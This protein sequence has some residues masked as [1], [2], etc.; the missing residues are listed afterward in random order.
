VTGPAGVEPATPLLEVA[1]LAVDFSTTAGTV[2]A[3]RDVDLT[4][5]AGE[6]LA[7]LGES[8]SGK[9]VTALAVMGL[10]PKSSATI[11]SGSVRYDGRDLGA[12][13]DE[14]RRR[15]RGSEIAMVFQDPLSSLNPV[16]T[17]GAQIDEVFRTHLG[18][19]KRD[20]RRRTVELM[21]RVRIDRAA[22]RAD[23]YPHQFS[24]GMRQRI[25]IA[26]AIALKPRVLIADEP[27]TALD[28]T[29]QARIIDLLRELRDEERMSLLF[30]THDLGVVATLADEVAV[31]Y[32]GRVVERGALR[33]VYDHPRHPYTAG[34][35]ASLPQL[36]SERL[37]PIPGNPPNML[38]VPAGCAF[39]P[40][41]A[42]AVDACR[43]VVPPLVESVPGH[44]D[45]CLRSAEIA[46]VLE[47][48]AR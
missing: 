33:E 36:G 16:F 41:C 8:G 3:L 24:G 39:A 48:A 7:I 13:D 29:V 22:E 4:V 6:T 32:A 34:L 12:L 47:E 10:L 43:A 9:S 35:M 26:M 25:M 46:G 42:F 19:S 28:V 18:L 2:H 15:I 14:E 17:V 31:M 11:A 20:A 21:D 30:I 45:A 27:T 1:N 44:R 23:D 38:Q 40:R 5:R 37:L